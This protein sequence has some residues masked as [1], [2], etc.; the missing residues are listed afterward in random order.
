L[1]R[2]AARIATRSASGLRIAGE[3]VRDALLWLTGL[4]G[5][6]AL[7]EPSP[8]ELVAILAMV[9]FLPGGLSLSRHLVPL[10]LLL[11]LINVGYAIAVVPVSGEVK[12]VTWVL[13]SAFLAVT[14]VFYAAILASATQRRLELLLRGYT[15][16]AI[17]ASLIAAAA[18]FRLLGGA[19]DLFLLYGRARGTFNDPNVLGGFLV[20]PSLLALQ[21]LL[22]GR[23]V[24][25]NALALLIMLVGLFLTFSRGAWG[26]LAF[27]AALLMALTYITSRSASERARAW[28]K[29][30][31]SAAPSWL[32]RR[33]SSSPM[34]RRP[35]AH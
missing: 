1:T 30:T 24:A 2:A 25:R 9:A 11:S 18:Y 20:L 12:P 27:A 5:A 34:R 31:I 35:C 6:F 7:I 22:A 14:A 19:S 26:Q 29:A 8:Y 4:A 28:S 16:A 13:I 33:L 15:A 23:R 10:L 32:T 17:I 21:A 3:S